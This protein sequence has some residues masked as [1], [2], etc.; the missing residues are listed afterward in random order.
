MSKEMSFS[1]ALIALQQGKQIKLSGVSYDCR[2]LIINDKL[3]INSVNG[4]NESGDKVND[5]INDKFTL[6]EPEQ[7]FKEVVMYAPV[8]EGGRVLDWAYDTKEQAL[9]SKHVGREIIGYAPVTV[10]IKE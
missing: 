7:K 1:E 2:Y 6:V 8:Q 4:W 10:F 3:M 9:D 5:L